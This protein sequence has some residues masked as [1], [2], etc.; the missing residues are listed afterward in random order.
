MHRVYMACLRS[1]V[2]ANRLNWGLGVREARMKMEASS[3]MLCPFSRRISQPLSV[4]VINVIGSC[5]DTFSFSPV[6]ASSILTHL[7]SFQVGSI[8]CQWRRNGGDG[9]VSPGRRILTS[10]GNPLAEL[11]DIRSALC[12]CPTLASCASWVTGRRIFLCPSRFF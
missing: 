7:T 5:L 8:C 2:R 1:P 4:S 9:G 10:A 11:C 12:A 3:E 6:S